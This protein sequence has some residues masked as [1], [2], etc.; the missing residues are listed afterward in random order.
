MFVMI[1]NRLFTLSHIKLL[2]VGLNVLKYFV[3]RYEI[4]SV[5]SKSHERVEPSILIKKRVETLILIKNV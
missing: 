3:F 5:F 2:Q 4:M 1:L